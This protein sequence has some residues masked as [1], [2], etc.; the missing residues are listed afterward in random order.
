MMRVILFTILLLAL[1]G[2]FLVRRNYGLALFDAVWTVIV[3]LC[4]KELQL[5]RYSQTL[6]LLVLMTV[7]V[8][9]GYVLAMVMEKKRSS[10]PMPTIRRECEERLVWALLGASAVIFGWYAVRTLRIYGFDLITIRRENN[11]ANPG[12]AFGSVADTLLFY[13][14][15]TPLI[16]TVI[17]VLAYNLSQGIAADP[18][19]YPV[20]AGVVLLQMITT[21]GGRSMFLRAALFFAAAI[22]WRLFTGRQVGGKW[23]VYLIGALAGFV[24]VME[25]V[26]YIRNKGEI[27]FIG[28]AVD[29]IRGAIAHMQYRLTRIREPQFYGGYVTFGGFLYYPVKLLSALTGWEIPT[30]NELMAFLQEYRK[31]QLYDRTMNYNA[32]VPNA[33]HFFYDSGYPGVVVFSALHGFILERAEAG[34]RRPTFFRFVLW[35]TCVYMIVYSALDGVLWAFRHPTTIWCCAI[36]GKYLYRPIKQGGNDGTADQCDRTDL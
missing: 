33:F 21:G 8:N 1:S 29:Y 25:A 11:T 10:V 17:L 18:R 31:V 35:A 32:L 2:T 7:M 9:A 30:S 16:Y 15:A 4:R 6:L 23:L 28:Q 5:P 22:L 36:L 13:G 34:C 3:F 24:I 14:V 12:S 26:T 27:T 20:V 19:L